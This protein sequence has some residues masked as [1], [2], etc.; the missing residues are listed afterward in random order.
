MNWNKELLRAEEENNMICR[1]CGTRN[2]N[3]AIV[4]SGCGEI[5]NTDNGYV[6]YENMDMPMKWY[7]FL[8]YFSCWFNAL[9]GF[10]QAYSMSK[11]R[12][13][14]GAG[15]LGAI[16]FAYEPGLKSFSIF[17]FVLSGILCLVS[18]YTLLKYMK[19][20]P[21]AVLANYIINLIWSIVIIIAV[22]TVINLDTLYGINDSQSTYFFTS[23]F[24]IGLN[25]ALTVFNAIYFNKRKHYFTN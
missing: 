20:A 8:A 25:V 13:F 15:D 19:I 7:K 17:I 3:K 9:Y 12:I 2:P 22:P 14:R 24:L 18:G 16:L 10:S 23:I 6:G 1:S 5:F 21:I 11:N 4:C